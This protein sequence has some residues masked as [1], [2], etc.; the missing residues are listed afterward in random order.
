MLY[1]SFINWRILIIRIL[2][3]VV[4]F[5]CYYSIN[6]Y[7]IRSH[8][9]IRSLLVNFV[10]DCR[11]IINIMFYIFFIIIILFNINFLVSNFS[12]NNALNLSFK[13]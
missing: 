11:E 8:G 9:K 10:F 2:I 13:Y 12:I 5:S 4:F 7:N 1:I 6:L 3:I